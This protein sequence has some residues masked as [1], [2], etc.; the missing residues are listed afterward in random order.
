MNISVYIE[1]IAHQ[2][3][4]CSVV[5]LSLRTPGRGPYH[6]P[7]S[8]VTA[9]N[10]SVQDYS[11]FQCEARKSGSAALICY[12]Q[13]TGGVHA[14]SVCKRKPHPDPLETEKCIHK[15]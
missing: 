11:N 5:T 15:L 7:L 1:T 4:H 12:A 2:M 6:F 8:L 10:D 9:V 3:I 13:S 14:E